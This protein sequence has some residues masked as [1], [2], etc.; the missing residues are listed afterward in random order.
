M[1][2][3][4]TQVKQALADMGSVLVAYSGGVDSTLLLKAA[5][6]ALGARAVGV[7]ALSELVTPPEATAALAVA[8][9]VIGADVVTVEVA[10]LSDP[11]F[12][13]NPP[14]RCYVCKR[15]IVSALLAYAHEH[16]FAVVADGS[17]AD[18]LSDYRPGARAA[19]ELGVRSPLQ[20]VGLTKAEIRALSRALG[21]PTWD[22]PSAACLASRLP[23][24]DPVTAAALAQIARAEAALRALGFREL[25]V[26]QHRDV[27]RI[28]LPPDAFPVAL[29]HREAIVAALKA[30]GYAY[31]TL[32]LQGLRSGSM[33]EPLE[34][35]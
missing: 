25:R 22:M 1:W 6:D 31:V 18:D 16:G 7:L 20:E 28:E 24:G 17:N 34:R 13:A 3:K 23:Y 21:L 9:E 14:E 32:D 4:Y 15:L 10:P 30:A 19:R 5:H 2:D 29:A 27:A 8:G 12:V 33:N 26:R 35:K 11:A